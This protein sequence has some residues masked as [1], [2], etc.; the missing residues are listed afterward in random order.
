LGALALMTTACVSQVETPVG[1]EVRAAYMLVE[2]RTDMAEGQT[3]P[4]RYDVTVNN[5]RTDPEGLSDDQEARMDAYA[6]GGL[7]EENAGETLLTFLINQ[8]TEAR[9][10]RRFTGDRPARLN[11]EIVSTIFPN[12]ATMMLVGEVIGL[13]YEFELVDLLTGEVVVESVEPIAPI[14]DRSAGA[15]AATD[16]IC[17]TLKTWPTPPP[18]S[19][20]RSSAAG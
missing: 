2:T 8:E 6:D 13:T 10:A 15:A 3:I 5:L 20:T 19:S 9:L 18:R 7:S 4:D 17:W 1:P 12:A 11:V 16:A 14:V